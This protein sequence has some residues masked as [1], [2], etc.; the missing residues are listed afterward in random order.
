MSLKKKIKVK[1]NEDKKVDLLHKAV[2]KLKKKSFTINKPKLK[3]LARAS[4]T[5]TAE[6]KEEIKKSEIT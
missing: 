4:T 2:G 1:T 5:E 6:K 3:G